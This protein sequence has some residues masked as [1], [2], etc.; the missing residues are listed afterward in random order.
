MTIRK[1]NKKKSLVQKKVSGNVYLAK[2]P[3]K[4]K[5]LQKPVEPTIKTG[6]IVTNESS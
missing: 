6:I 5:K 3:Q 1:N 4:A 2:K